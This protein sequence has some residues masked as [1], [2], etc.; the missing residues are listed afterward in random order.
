MNKPSN[1]EKK[2]LWKALGAL[3]TVLWI[4]GSI[5]HG[6]AIKDVADLEIKVETHVK[7]IA[8]LE[9][10]DALNQMALETM[11]NKQDEIA[12]TLTEV[13]DL[14]LVINSKIND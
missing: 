14:V 1:G 4:A 5:I 8:A 2:L 7:E 10:R 6:Y 13:R 11:G 12:E 3:M 9:T